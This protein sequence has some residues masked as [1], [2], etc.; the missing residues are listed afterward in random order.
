MITRSKIRTARPQELLDFANRLDPDGSVDHVVAAFLAR[1]ALELYLRN[2]SGV[3]RKR[4]RAR[5][6]GRSYPELSPIAA[7]A[8]RL[9]RQASA[10]IHYRKK[11][12]GSDG[13]DGLQL[14]E[15]ARKLIGC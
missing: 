14:V 8:R 4:I 7:E 3:T 12:I 2:R 13:L 9:M 5:R 1:A 11:E 10:A 6:L 15:E